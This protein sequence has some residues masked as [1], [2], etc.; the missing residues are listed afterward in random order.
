MWQPFLCGDVKGGVYN[1]RWCGELDPEGSPPARLLP[2]C[3][4]FRG[5]FSCLSVQVVAIQLFPA[6]HLSV[7]GPGVM[8]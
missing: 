2:G 1:V 3:G 8:F 4:A 6:I 7:E 5:G